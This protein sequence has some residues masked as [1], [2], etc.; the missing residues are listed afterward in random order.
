MHADASSATGL[1]DF[2]DPLYRHALRALLHAFDTDLH[3]TESGWE[4]AYERIV[5]TL[6]ARL[7]ARKGL[8]EHPEALRIQI[9]RPLVIIGLPRT[10][11]TALH[12]LLAIDPQFQG[13][14][15]WLSE[16]PMIRP[17]PETWQSHA[18]YRACLANLRARYARTP[19]AR[20]A[21]EVVAGEVEECGMLLMQSFASDVWTIGFGLPTYGRWLAAQDVRPSYRYY[22][23]VLRLIGAHQPQTR[24]LLK[25][26]SHMADI[27]A[28][29]EVYPDA[30]IVHTHR[31][32]LKAIP[33]FCSLR[34]MVQR[35]F[36]GEAARPDAIGPQ[37]SSYWR[38]ALDRVQAIRRRLPTQFFDV[39][40]RS[41]LADPLRVVRSLYDYFGL[42]LVSRTEQQMRAWVAAQPLSVHG[43]HQY[44]VESWGVTQSE[45]AALFAEYRA[46]HEFV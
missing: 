23:D 14:Q 43:R 39:D 22:V 37:Q 12:R 35:D 29:L 13:L 25:C 24:W 42:T 8:T 27:E 7:H 6:S 45:L 4:V 33:S 3:L 1:H 19:E 16:S 34:Y 5:R 28:L 30:C 15:T 10:G 40:H 26:P 21:H 18:S 31:D 44:P 46:Q 9:R 17:P 11:T 32:P 2:G 41:F 38:V 36:E 20:T